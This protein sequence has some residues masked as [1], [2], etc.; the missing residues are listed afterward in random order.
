M[1][2]GKVWS[3]ILKTSRVQFIK[4]LEERNH[5]GSVTKGV[6]HEHAN[7]VSGRS[8]GGMQSDKVDF[9]WRAKIGMSPLAQEVFTNIVF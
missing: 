5:A 9:K 7:K 4:F 3:A 6:G 2:R 8:T 1:N